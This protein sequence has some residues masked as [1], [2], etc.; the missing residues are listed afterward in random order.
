VREFS[1]LV[2][3]WNGEYVVREENLKDLGYF[4]DQREAV[5]QLSDRLTGLQ[6]LRGEETAAA[7][8]EALGKLKRPYLNPWEEKLLEFLERWNS[9]R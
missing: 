3:A 7:I 6:S 4:P 1:C 5:K 2:R 9:T 8:L